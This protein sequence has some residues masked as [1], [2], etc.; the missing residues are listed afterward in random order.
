MPLVEDE[1]VGDQLL[2]G[3]SHFRLLGRFA[4]VV[5]PDFV[6]DISD[7]KPADAAAHGVADDD[8][9]LLHGEAFFDRVEVVAQDGGGVHV[10]VAAGVAEDPEL[11]VAAD[12]LVVSEAVDHGRPGGG[13]GVQAVHD[14]DDGFV[15]VVG[16]EAGD[17]GGVSVFFRVDEA[18]EAHFFGIAVGEH[19]GDRD[20]EVGGQGEGFAIELDGF[21]GKGVFEAEFAGAAF[22]ACDGGDSVVGAGE[23]EV[24][25]GIG[26]GLF[27]GGDDGGAEAVLFVVFLD[28][29]TT[30]VELI[31]G[32]EGVEGGIPGFAGI[33]FAREDE[34]AVL[35]R[36]G[37]GFGPRIELRVLN[38][39]EDPGDSEIVLFADD[40][41]IRSERQLLGGDLSS[42]EVSSEGGHGFPFAPFEGVVK[43]LMN[44]ADGANGRADG[45]QDGPDLADFGEVLATGEERAQGEREEEVTFH[46]AIRERPTF[47]WGLR[48]WQA[49]VQ[50]QSTCLWRVLGWQRGRGWRSSGARVCLRR[51][52]KT[53]HRSPGV[54][55]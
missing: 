14:E 33:G 39:G 17:A 26:V 40:G 15:R 55:W 37:E 43:G 12:F 24:F 19:D 20:G 8:H 36:D 1:G 31:R 23:R 49:S 47:G 3:G 4:E 11:V 38:H 50:S 28:E 2:G 46:R 25:F 41:V 22:E 21:G 18:G 44:G 6:A 48:E 13:G 9:F 29:G 35:G 5:Q 34:V 52:K 53:R 16:L 10:R 51:R 7:E 54:R 32:G 42:G 30:D 27:A 45:A